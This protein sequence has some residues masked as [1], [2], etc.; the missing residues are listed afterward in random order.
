VALLALAVAA[1]TCSKTEPCALCGSTVCVDTKVDSANCGGC[2]MACAAGTRC[3]QGQ[4]MNAR[5]S[6]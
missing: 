1:T 6:P 5:C 4:R 2:G 3:E